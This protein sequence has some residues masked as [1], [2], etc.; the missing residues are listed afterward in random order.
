MYPE[1]FQ[2]VIDA[3]GLSD[4]GVTAQGSDPFHHRLIII[5]DIFDEIFSQ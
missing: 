2:L 3:Q 1:L 4:Q 5:P